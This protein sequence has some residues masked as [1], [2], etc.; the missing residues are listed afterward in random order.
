MIQAIA[1]ILLTIF[2]FI[3]N[4]DH[5]IPP[6]SAGDILFLCVIIAIFLPF[7]YLIMWLFTRLGYQLALNS[8]IKAVNKK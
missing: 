3:L 2:L 4:P 1:I 5:T 8:M 7:I 6:L